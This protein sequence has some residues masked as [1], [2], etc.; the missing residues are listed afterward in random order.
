MCTTIALEHFV[1][2]A[3]DLVLQME[4]QILDDGHVRAVRKVTTKSVFRAGGGVAIPAEKSGKRR[5]ILHGG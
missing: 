1:G 2:N 4:L 3:N 5:L